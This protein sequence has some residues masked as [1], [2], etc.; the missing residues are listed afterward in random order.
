VLVSAAETGHLLSP[1]T[2]RCGTQPRSY[3]ARDS[4]SPPADRV[5]GERRKHGL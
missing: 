1:R 2:R 4:D 3:A 5:R